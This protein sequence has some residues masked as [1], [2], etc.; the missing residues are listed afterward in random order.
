M[1]VALEWRVRR[2]FNMMVAQNGHGEHSHSEKEPQVS[3]WKDLCTLWVWAY[4][5]RWEGWPHIDNGLDQQFYAC[6]VPEKC[7]VIIW[8]SAGWFCNVH[9]NDGGEEKSHWQW[10]PWKPSLP[11]WRA[12]HHHPTLTLGN[13]MMG[14]SAPPRFL[15]HPFHQQVARSRICHWWRVREWKTPCARLCSHLVTLGTCPT[16][17][18]QVSN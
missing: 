6:A 3:S 5:G 18:C 15:R 11:K 4:D 17:F 2:I 10:S 8:Y 9:M 13:L 14:I 7:P 1:S 12:S 16:Y